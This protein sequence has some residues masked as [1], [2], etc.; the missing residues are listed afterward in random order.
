M[1]S[2]RM[3]FDMEPEEKLKDSPNQS[4]LI[5]QAAQ[6]LYG[7]TQ[8]CYIL[9]KHGIAQMLEKYQQGDFGYCHPMCAL[10]TRHPT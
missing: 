3:V 9:T 10:R 4:D 7:L 5:K 6:M 8:A 1:T 2:S